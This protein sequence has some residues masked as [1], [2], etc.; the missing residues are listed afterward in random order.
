MIRVDRG[1]EYMGQFAEMVSQHGVEIDGIALESAWQLGKAE[2]RGGVFK[3]V[4]I[5]VVQETRSRAW[6]TYNARPQ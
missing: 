6:T 3:G 4:W 5:K 2:R 1:K